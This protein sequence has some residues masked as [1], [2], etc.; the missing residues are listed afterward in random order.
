MNTVTRLSAG[1]CVVLLAGCM[2][3]DPYSGEKK[4]SSASKGA[5]IGAGVAALG[6]F[7]ANKDDSS[8]TRNQRILQTATAGAAIGG[9]AGYYMD[10]QEAE[11]RHQLMD[12]GV[13]VERVGDELVLIL[14][15]N[16]TFS[17]NSSNIRSDF[18]DVL[19]SVSAILKKFNK[20]NISIAGHTDSSGSDSYNMM[21]SRERAQSVSNVLSASGVTAQRLSTRGFG[22]SQPIAD[23]RTAAG[24]AA[25]RRVELKL[26]PTE[27]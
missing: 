13:Q 8:R 15:S 19:Q 21:L 14:P 20:T 5:A 1:F 25:N 3:Y 23:N 22:E 2:T 16:I 18:N 7:A 10:R 27:V 11:L 26:I 12:T 6:A 9:G 4:V 24:K 17:V